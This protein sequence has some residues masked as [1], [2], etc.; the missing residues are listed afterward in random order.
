[1]HARTHLGNAGKLSQRSQPLSPKYA[2]SNPSAYSHQ[3]IIFKLFN[4]EIFNSNHDQMQT[5][6]LSSWEEPLP[7]IIYVGCRKYTL[8]ISVICKSHPLFITAI[9]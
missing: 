3:I 2:H 9:L 7:Q 1:M 8:I 6:T 4:E 5:R